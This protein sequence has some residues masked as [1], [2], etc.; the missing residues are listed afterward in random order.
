MTYLELATRSRR[1]IGWL[2]DTSV[3]AALAWLP[4]S[5]PHLR[6]SPAAWAVS[7]AIPPAYY[8]L[9][10]LVFR[11]TLGKALVRTVVVTDTGGMPGFRQVLVRTVARL[12]PLDLFWAVFGRV[13]ALHDDMSN[14]I[15]VRLPRRKTARPEASNPEGNHP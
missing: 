2:I 14:T 11:R 6:H 15:V 4:F 12:I 10:E 13:T 9:L 8:V 1:L 5:H 7:V 3:I